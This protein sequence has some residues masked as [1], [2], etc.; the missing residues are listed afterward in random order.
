MCEV[1][2]TILQ[3]STISESE[4]PIAQQPQIEN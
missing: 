1:Y 2:V 4:T 3:L